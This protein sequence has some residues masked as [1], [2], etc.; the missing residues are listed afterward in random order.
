MDTAYKERS[1]LASQESSGGWFI[2]ATG[3]HAAAERLDREKHPVQDDEPTLSFLSEHQLLLGLA[4]ENLLKGFI[5][6]VRLKTGQKP[7][8][9]RDCYV[10]KLEA[11]ATRVECGELALTADKIMFLSRLSPYIK[12]A[13][14][15]PIPRKS[16]ELIVKVS[17]S[18]V[19]EQNLWAR[20]APLLCKRVRIM[21]GGLESMGGYRLYLDLETRT[22]NNTSP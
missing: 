18:R 13:G 7:A 20:I 1:F 10:H 11:L 16:T 15:Y 5:V 9:P 2:Q 12:W 14:R 17:G 3:L 8:L 22:L 4:F 21:K 6:L 19:V